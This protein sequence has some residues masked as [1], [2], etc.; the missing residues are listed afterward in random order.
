MIDFKK[1]F[2]NPKL[3]VIAGIIAGAIVVG[4]ILYFIFGYKS[5]EQ[6]TNKLLTENFVNTYILNNNTTFSISGK[7]D[8]DYHLVGSG[9]SGGVG[10]QVLKGTF[11]PTEGILYSVSIGRMN[12]DT[13]LNGKDGTN[14]VAKANSGESGVFLMLGNEKYYLGYNSGT[15]PITENSGNTYFYGNGDVGNS[16]VA[17]IQTSGILIEIET[18]TSVN[19]TSCYPMDNASMT[20]T[21]YCQ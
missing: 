2:E 20:T 8:I 5:H 1:I 7:D 12:G 18:N 11:T 19:I 21:S 17:I 16:G 6:Y 13:I 9:H 14:I 3:Q 4:I 15:L 10:G